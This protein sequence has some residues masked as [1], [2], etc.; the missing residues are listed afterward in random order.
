MYFD[1]VTA[2]GALG[3]ARAASFDY[4]KATVEAGVARVVEFLDAF[5]AGD[6][7]G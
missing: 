2:N 4:G 5:V 6:R 1:E 7:T 3:D